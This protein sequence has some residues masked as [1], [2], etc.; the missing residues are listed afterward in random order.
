MAEKP[1]DTNLTR[2]ARRSV[3]NADKINEAE[4]FAE[5]DFVP[6]KE[7]NELKKKKNIAKKKIHK[8]ERQRK[9]K[10]RKRK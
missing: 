10:A 2:A 1:V 3:A 9:S 6:K 8:A 7:A 5:T 4:D